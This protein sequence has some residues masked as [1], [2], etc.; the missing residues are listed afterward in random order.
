M[1]DI[2]KNVMVSYYKHSIFIIL[3]R[4]ADQSQ[5]VPNTACVLKVCSDVTFKHSRIPR[6]ERDVQ[7]DHRAS[8]RGCPVTRAQ[9][10]TSHFSTWLKAL[11]PITY[12]AATI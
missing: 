7:M 5:L 6:F 8:E 4:N 11:F 10:E 9:H 2:C 3:L 12:Q 1:N